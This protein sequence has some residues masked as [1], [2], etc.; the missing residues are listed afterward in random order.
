VRIWVIGCSTG[1]EA[2]SLAIA[3]AEFMETTR[4]I[5]LQMFATEIA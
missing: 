2:Y 1:S 5:P 3:Y 4:Q